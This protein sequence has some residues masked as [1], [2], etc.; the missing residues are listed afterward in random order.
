M[1]APQMTHRVNRTGML[2]TAV[3]VVIG[4]VLLWV[5]YAKNTQ[6]AHTTVKPITST[7]QAVSTTKQVKADLDSINVNAQLDTSEI[8]N[9]LNNQ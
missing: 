5:Y 6:L 3:A 2:V 4:G 9:V 7:A 1:I 8:D